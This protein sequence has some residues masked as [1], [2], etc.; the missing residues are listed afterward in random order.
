MSKSKSREDDDLERP[1]NLAFQ[2]R[3]WRVQRIAWIVMGLVLA[4]T[5]VG[6][7]GG[8]PLAHSRVG[9]PANGLFLEYD[10]IARYRALSTLDFY[11]LSPPAGGELRLWIARDFLDVIRLHTITPEPASQELS[12]DR[13][14]YVFDATGDTPLK[15]RF[16]VEPNAL[17]QRG[18][19]AGVGDEQPISFSQFVLP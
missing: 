8:G 1:S 13:I 15:V 9:S 17:W 3:E 6:V 16:E 18:G 7:F 4:A 10:R 19:R 2:Q 11:V 5:L 12:S 14:S